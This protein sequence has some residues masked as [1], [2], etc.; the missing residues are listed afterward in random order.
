MSIL[1]IYV[2]GTPTC[3]QL[4]I[5]VHHTIMH[6]SQGTDAILH[7]SCLKL[8]KQRLLWQW[9]NSEFKPS[10]HTEQL[11]LQDG[12]FRLIST[13]R[14]VI[15]AILAYPM[16]RNQSV[17]TGRSMQETMLYRYQAIAP[18]ILNIMLINDQPYPQLIMHYIYTVS[19]SQIQ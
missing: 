19:D 17:P 9:C 18:S 1:L 6:Y 8:K 5:V 15:E 16:K 10:L 12:P 7:V 2:H 3:A 13:S 11:T 4:P 14:R